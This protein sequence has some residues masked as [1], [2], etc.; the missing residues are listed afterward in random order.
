VFRSLSSIGRVDRAILSFL[1]SLLIVGVSFGDEERTRPTLL[2]DTP[3]RDTSICRG[4]DAF[5]I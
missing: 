4:H 3:I 1:L 5:G 2:F